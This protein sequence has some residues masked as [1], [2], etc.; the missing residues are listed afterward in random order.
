MWEPR[1]WY[2]TCCSQHCFVSGRTG[3]IKSNQIF[4]IVTMCWH[5]RPPP[6]TLKTDPKLLNNLCIES[7]EPLMLY[8]ATN[9]VI[10]IRDTKHGKANLSEG[11]DNNYRYLNTGQWNNLLRLFIQY[12]E[13]LDGTLCGWKDEIV[14]FELKPDAKPCHSRPLPILQL[15]EESSIK[16]VA[17][18]VEKRS[19]ETHSGI[20]MD[21]SIIYHFK[22][23]KIPKSTTN[24]TIHVW[25][26]RAKQICHKQV[27]PT[28]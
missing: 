8:V 11:V 15:K 28:P 9:R 3:Y 20:W 5:A 21:L 10:H 26:S 18:L 19:V 13:L 23:A 25:P 6:Q 16:E 27:L 4:Q 14:N 2:L 22:E 24:S 1:A 7:T 12:E 17:Q